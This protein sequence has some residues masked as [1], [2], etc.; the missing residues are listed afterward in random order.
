MIPLTTSIDHQWTSNDR[1]KPVLTAGPVN[2]SIYNLFANLALSAGEFWGPPP[3][4]ISNFE[5]FC[6]C[7]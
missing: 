3:R 7:F 2:M 5:G 4:I 6:V 1:L